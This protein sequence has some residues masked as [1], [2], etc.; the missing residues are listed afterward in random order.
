MIK[1]FPAWLAIEKARNIERHKAEPSAVYLWKSWSQ[2]CVENC[3]RMRVAVRDSFVHLQDND[4]AGWRFTRVGCTAAMTLAYRR[5]TKRWQVRSEIES[6]KMRERKLLTYAARTLF[7]ARAYAEVSRM[8]K[9]LI[10]NGKAKEFTATW[11]DAST[12]AQGRIN[13]S[14][15][16]SDP[17]T[18]WDSSFRRNRILNQNFNR[19]NEWWEA[20]AR[21]MSHL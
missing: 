10:W 8:A 16:R 1:E 2:S 5:N 12:L 9:W 19:N 17:P 6:R 13:H 3:K 15:V 14:P 11:S 18:E 20:Y 4:Y 7:V 21:A